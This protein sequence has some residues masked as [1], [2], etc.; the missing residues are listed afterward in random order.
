MKKNIHP[1]Y[2]PMKVTLS[3]GEVVEINSVLGAKEGYEMHLDI[4]SNNH[5]AYTKSKDFVVVGSSQRNKF[6]GRFAGMF[7]ASAKKEEK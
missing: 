5:P 7:A 1:E 6:E 4:D 2:G 3:T